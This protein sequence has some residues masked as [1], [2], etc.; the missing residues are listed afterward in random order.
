M[1]SYAGARALTRLALRRDVALLAGWVAAFVLVA[2]VSAA[3]TV[4]FYPSSSR[5]AA[6]DAVNRSQALVA[7]YGRVYDPTSIGAL[8]MIKT[9]SLG[10]VF[11]AMLT[12]VLVVRHTRADE[13]A[14]RTELA[15]GTA[16]GR[17]AP[18]AA[19]LLL[20]LVANLLLAVFTAAA[21]SVAGLPLD[22]SIAF[23]L[24]WA[25]VGLTFAA[26]AGAVAQLTTS[27]RTAVTLSAA[28]L[29]VVYVLRALGDT[30]GAGGP[31]W[32][33]WLSPIGWA[34][35]FRPYAGNRWW[36]LAI[37]LGFAAVV[38]F[39]AFV[40]ASRRDLGAGLL[41]T[42][43][44]PASAS[45]LLGSPLALAWRLHRGALVGWAVAF[46]AVGILMG[47]VASNV[48]DFLNNP[49]ARDFITKLG[50]QKG[51]IDA[52]LAVELG[53]AGVVASAYGIQVVMRL[54]SEETGL[55]AEPVL[56]TAV[57]RVRWAMS[58]ISIALGGT[59]LLL[60]L[61]GAG[62]GLARSVQA[63]AASQ[64]APILVGAL[65]QLPAVWVLAAIVVAAYGLAP[66]LVAIGWVA[67]AGFVLLGELGPLLDLS[68]WAM[69]ISPFAHVPK[70]PGGT[71]STM[72]IVVLTAVAALL[73]GVGLVGL[74]VRDI[75]TS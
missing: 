25:G 3:A 48:G 64:F 59:A 67:L 53:F 22:G 60:V 7:L 27:A 8:S 10:A 63:G 54:R 35:Q 28:V 62:A 71:F 23:G 6:A 75:A 57:G 18:L 33:S 37:T 45:R 24:A 19:A 74:H 14:G 69:D 58:H 2:A 47:G 73:G 9:G 5:V 1:S 41:R 52:F 32:L 55:H 40:L 16:L 39:A 4:D 43:D 56:A 11:V 70:L 72:S 26:I 36:V 66:R 20:A 44:G 42:R 65:V 38:A 13:E 50:G 49:S 15:G 46:A 17:G 34:Q 31:R 51:L 29:G 30:A 21:L 68:Q 61:A 12:V